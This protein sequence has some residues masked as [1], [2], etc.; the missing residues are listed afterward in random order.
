MRCT[1]EGY[2]SK[3]GVPVRGSYVSSFSCHRGAAN[4]FLQR[5]GLAEFLVTNVRCLVPRSQL[6][7]VRGAVLGPPVWLGVGLTCAQTASVLA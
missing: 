7:L 4:V 6:H 1:R 5:R 3:L 2:L